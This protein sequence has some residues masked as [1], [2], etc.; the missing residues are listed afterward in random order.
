LV[1]LRFFAG[2]TMPEAA[3]TLGLSVAT[4]E[5]YWAFARAWLHAQL[6][7]GED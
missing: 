5:R 6:T 4:A 7:D 1:K 2:L 3:A